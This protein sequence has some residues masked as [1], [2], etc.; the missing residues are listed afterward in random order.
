MEVVADTV[1]KESD[2]NMDEVYIE[3]MV[4]EDMCKAWVALLEK[5]KVAVVDM[6]ETQ[7]MGLMMVL[8]EKEE[9][10][11]VASYLNVD[12]V[13]EQYLWELDLVDIHLE[14]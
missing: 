9:S 12:V 11:E 14:R 2:D 4:V 6:E 1:D 10:E 7:L 8:L 3:D 13:L 5:N